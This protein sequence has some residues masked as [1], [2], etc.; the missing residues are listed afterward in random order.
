M[1]DWLKQAI[2]PMDILIGV[3]AIY[4]LVFEIDY[5]NMT[6]VD[7]IYVV[8]FIIWFVLLAVRCYIYWKKG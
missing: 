3:A 1:Q 4:L 2:K 6:T 5:S 7:T 8:C